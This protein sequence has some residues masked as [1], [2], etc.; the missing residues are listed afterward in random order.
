M[1]SETV[2]RLY[3][4]F[5]RMNIDCGDFCPTEEQLDL[6]SKRI[7]SPDTAYIMYF[8]LW[9]QDKGTKTEANAKDRKALSRFISSV[10]VIP[11]DEN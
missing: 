1:N 7:G 10:L 5:D 11:E 6:L 8:L 3:E 2:D 4:I 9:I